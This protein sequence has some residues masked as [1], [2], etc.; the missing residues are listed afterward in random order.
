MASEVITKFKVEG[1][2][3]YNQK[4]QGVKST[5]EQVGVKGREAGQMIGQMDKI[6]GTNIGTL[7]KL[8]VAT[9]AA[10]SALKVMKD[11]FFAS[12]SNIDEW[13]RITESAKAAYDTF[14]NALNT[15]NW[16]GFFSRLNEAIGGARELYDMFDKLGSTKLNNA[17][18]IA[19]L[20]NKLSELRLLKQQGKDVGEQ[21]KSVSDAL[22]KLKGEEI[23]IGKEANAQGWWNTVADAG[24]DK[25]MAAQFW[26]RY[27]KEGQ[28]FYEWAKKE[29]EKY[30]GYVAPSAENHYQGYYRQNTLSGDAE[31]RYK[32]LLAIV[33]KETQLQ[34]YQSGYAQTIQQAGALNQSQYKYNRWGSNLKSGGGRG[35][36]LGNGGGDAWSMIGMGDMEGLSGFGS[37]N[38]AKEMLKGW[39]EALA[40]ATTDAGRQTA[41]KYIEALQAQIATMSAGENPLSAYVNE[42]LGSIEIPP[43]QVDTDLPDGKAFAKDWSAAANAIGQLGSALNS[44]EDPAAKVMGTVML[45]IAN[46]AATFAQ[47]LKG[48]FTPW[49]WIAAAASGTATMISTIAAI[50]SATAGSFT[51]GGVIGGNSYYGDKLYA[52]VNSGEAILNADQSRRALEMM[53]GA[54]GGS[55]MVAISGEVIKIA[56]NNHLRSIGV[57]G[58]KLVGA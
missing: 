45:A 16:E 57:S 11:A 9:A 33:E 34:Q 47:S 28:K 8:S 41:V 44:I 53:D 58:D 35:G 13:G 22:A 17:V 42:M 32:T 55:G 19:I 4:V 20:E 25:K 56:L 50:K 10:S 23:K 37:I 3:Q 48:T 18:P 7:G 24:G 12:E 52:R 26:D 46:I 43:L 54:G 5:L 49:D 51:N 27:K 39:Q 40:A 36:S 38:E 14:L 31:K 1:I 2:S 15:G 29:K 30:E 21:I 6:L